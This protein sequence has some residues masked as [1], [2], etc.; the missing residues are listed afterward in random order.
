MA[1]PAQADRHVGALGKG[2]DSG[3]GRAGEGD[4]TQDAAVFCPIDDPLEDLAALAGDP[5]ERHLRLLYRNELRHAVGRNVATHAHVRDGERKAYRLET[6]WL[7]VYDVPA[8]IAPPA[9]DGS[10]LAGVELSMDEL[11][12]LD[13][14]QLAEK[15]APLADGYGRWLDEQQARIPALPEPLRETARTAVFTARQ[16]ADRIRAG[17]RL[18]TLPAAAGHGMALDAFRFANQAMALQRRHTV[19]AALREAE[20]LS[21]A[22]AK[23]KVDEEGAVRRRGGRSSS[24]SSC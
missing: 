19:M 1:V 24:R 8:T 23:A 16:C 6:T 9:E 5:E 17:I 4:E 14:G 7:P 11:A 18:L 13:A 15:L 12:T 2:G 3:W 21:F 22:E 20:G 10:H